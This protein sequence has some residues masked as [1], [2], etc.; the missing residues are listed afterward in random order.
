MTRSAIVRAAQFALALATGAA[1]AAALTGAPAAAQGRQITSYGKYCG[2]G[3][4]AFTAAIGETEGRLADLAGQWPPADDLDALCYSHDMCFEKLGMDSLTCDNAVEA[5]FASF[6]ASFQQS[7]TA[8]SAQA[9]NMAEAFRLKLWSKGEAGGR[10]EGLARGFNNLRALG[11]NDARDAALRQVVA[12]VAAKDCNLG[13]TPDPDYA[14]DQF[15][16]HVRGQGGVRDFA[17]CT[18]D[19][20]AAGAC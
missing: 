8:C 6:A 20:A 3:V 15:V 18:P 2:P 4:P 10:A 5:T 1:S 9:T 17:I 19:D 11:G 16:A 13:A 14:V 7:R 12:E